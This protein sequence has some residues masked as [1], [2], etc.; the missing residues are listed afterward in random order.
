MEPVKHILWDCPSSKDVWGVC[1]KSIQ[2]AQCAC[3]EFLEV[4]EVMSK[5]C[6]KEEMDLFVI[7]ARGIWSRQNTVVHGGLF[8]HPNYLEHDAEDLLKQFGQARRTR[9]KVNPRPRQ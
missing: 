2:K 5:R 7:L 8:H 4:V 1:N 9:E 6:S 3:S